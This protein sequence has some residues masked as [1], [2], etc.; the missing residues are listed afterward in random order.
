MASSSDESPATPP[1]HQVVEGMS[2]ERELYGQ[3]FSAEEERVRQEGWRVLCERFFQPLVDPASVLVDLGAGDGHFIRHMRARVRVAV[4]L[5]DHVKVCGQYGAQVIQAPGT[6]FAH[7]LPERADVI[8]MSNFLEHMPTRHVV[9]AVLA[10][11]WR[12]LKP[13]GRVIILQPNARHA[14]AAYW[15]YI[16]HHIALT[17]HSLAEAV[18]LSGFRLLQTIPQFLPFTAKS[19]LGVVARLSPAFAMRAY[20]A[21]PAAWKLLGAQCLVVAERP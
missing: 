8:F 18:T 20:L 14:G 12:A 11:C 7:L 5:S 15:D 13:G 16:D 10:E 21:F 2:V 4:D 19:T 1:V 9:L 3:R 17:E 6:S